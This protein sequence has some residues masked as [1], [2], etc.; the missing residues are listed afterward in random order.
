[1]LVGLACN[2]QGELWL[3]DTDF[4]QGV[5]VGGSPL[6]LFSGFGFVAFWLCNT[7]PES[8]SRRNSQRVKC[9]P[10]IHKGMDKWFMAHPGDGLWFIRQKYSEELSM[11]YRICLRPLWKNFN[12]N[13]NWRILNGESHNVPSEEWN[14]KTKRLI[15]YKYLIYK[16]QRL[17]LAN[18]YS[19]RIPPRLQANELTAWALAELTPLYTPCPWI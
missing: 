16:R 13:W 8:T 5:L 18:E 3:C 17:F 10:Q 15:S 7:T 9:S 6:T 2:S 11:T 19:P 4:Q 12:L 1:M 14:L